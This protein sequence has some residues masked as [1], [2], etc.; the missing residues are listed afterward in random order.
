MPAGVGDA[1]RGRL[2][3]VVAVV[4]AEQHDL[5]AVI[6]AAQKPWLVPLGEWAPVVGVAVLP[7]LRFKSP[8][9]RRGVA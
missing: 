8:S 4:L 5:G 3:G 1:R 6:L 9:G 2:G 7:A